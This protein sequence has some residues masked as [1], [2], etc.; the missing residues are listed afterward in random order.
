[1]EPTKC[2]AKE[3]MKQEKQK[4]RGG[5]KLKSTSQDYCVILKPVL[6]SLRY[7][8]NIH[9]SGR[10]DVKGSLTSDNSLF[11]ELA[12]TYST[13]HPTMHLGQGCNE[14]ASGFA[15]GVI[16]GAQWKELHYT[17]QDYAYLMLNIPQL[18]FFISCC[19]YP[20]AE[21]LKNIWEA[22]REPLLAFLA[23]SHQAV[24]GVVHTLDHRPVNTSTVSVKGPG[25]SF[26]LKQSDSYFHQL[27][28]QGKYKITATAPG[29]ASITKE[30]TIHENSR[31]SV[32][33]NL[34]EKPQFSYHNYEAMERFLRDIVTKCPN[35]TR[36]Y[37]I[38]QTV[39]Y[40]NIWVMEISDNPGLHEQ[41]EPEFRYVGGVHGNEAVGKE[42]L[43]LMIQHLCLSYGKDDLVTRLVNSTRIHI[44]PS[45]NSDGS[46]VAIKGNCFTDKGRNNARDVDLYTNFP[47]MFRPICCYFVVQISLFI[48]FIGI[49][50]HT[51]KQRKSDM[52]PQH[53]QAPVVKTL[54]SA[55]HRDI[56]C[57][58]H[59]IEIYPLDNVSAL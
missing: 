25:I 29:Y 37:S 58:I 50:Y 10:D 32:M 14:S 21:Q 40:R 20:P 56:K 1:M 54:D 4:K 49:H 47:G 13:K 7:P 57:A 51:Q 8:M 6:F 33:F 2:P 55:I 45:L 22:N 26:V 28:P 24:D 27:L 59:W 31:A 52:N 19:K 3:N 42:M 39:Q 18:S 9:M 11:K 17:M 30:V 44:L 15:D 38:G 34:H 23:K 53:A 46:E 41:G 5:E 16:N 12:L 35:I 36:L 48:G 43:L